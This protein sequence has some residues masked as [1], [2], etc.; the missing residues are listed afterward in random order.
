MLHTEGWA[1]GCRDRPAESNVKVTTVVHQRL[2]GSQAPSSPSGLAHLHV[3][4]LL[5]AK[6]CT[7]HTLF[8]SSSVSHGGWILRG[9]VC[10]CI[11]SCASK[12]FVDS[13]ASRQHS[14]LT[15]HLQCCRC[16]HPGQQAAGLP[17]CCKPLR[18]SCW[19]LQMQHHALQVPAPISNE[20]PS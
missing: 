11:S 2:Q 17:Y 3:H 10:I 18:H 19:K 9:E 7:D 8:L 12:A 16:S 6:E 5:L 13:Y 4:V 15:L 1:G 20:T 14:T